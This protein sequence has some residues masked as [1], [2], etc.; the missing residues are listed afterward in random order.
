MVKL[1]SAGACLRRWVVRRRD[2]IRPHDDLAGFSHELRTPLSVLSTRLHAMS[3]GIRPLDQEQV[4]LLSG[5]VRELEDLVDQFHQLVMADSGRLACRRDPLHWDE[6]IHAGLT[7]VKH[8]FTRRHLTLVTRIESDVVILGD[9]THLQRLLHYVLDNCVRYSRAGGVVTV[10]LI[11]LPGKAE[12]S[13]TDTGP[14]VSEAQRRQ[15]FDRFYRTEASRNRATG[16]RG[17]GLALVRTLAEAHDGRVRAYHTSKG[18]L[19]IAV[20][21]PL[22]PPA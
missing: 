22:A 17:L 18:G 20:S 6:L 14:G 15:L 21:L 9:A 1:T 10:S 7:D 3:D 2:R 16:G 19:G 4:A 12:L 11:S 8:R 5:S 13:V